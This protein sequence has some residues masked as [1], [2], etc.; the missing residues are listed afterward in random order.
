MPPRLDTRP[1]SRPRFHARI[2]GGSRTFPPLPRRANRACMPRSQPSCG[3]FLVSQRLGVSPVDSGFSPFLRVRSPR[4]RASASNP[5]PIFQTLP[6]E[7]PKTSLWQQN[8][9]VHFWQS[10]SVPF[11]SDRSLPFP[12]ARIVWLAAEPVKA[13]LRR[14]QNR[15]AALTEPAASRNP[16]SLT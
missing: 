10:R 6:G 11:I 2:A 15:R 7:F 9:N 1:L 5:G 12:L 8:R 13:A 14:A 16:F 3:P 4:L